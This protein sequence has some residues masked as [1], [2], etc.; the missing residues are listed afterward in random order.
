MQQIGA[1]AVLYGAAYG[2]V[3]EGTTIVSRGEAVIGTVYCR[4]DGLKVESHEQEQI[5]KAL[6]QHIVED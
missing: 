2:I 6:G 1:E 5:R 4:G 3:T